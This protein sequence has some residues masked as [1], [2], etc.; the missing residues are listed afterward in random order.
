M[1]TDLK[2]QYFPHDYNASYDI[3]I[4]AIISEC[5]AIGYGIYWRIIEELHKEKGKIK[6]ND[7]VLRA[8]AKQMR[9]DVEQISKV[10]DTGIECDLF[11]KNGNNILCS[12]RVER[13]LQKRKEISKK[14][15]MA[16]KASGKS[17]KNKND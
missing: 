5:G 17:R 9:T 16:G 12:K 3:K 14:R 6:M 7:P 2:D 4:L 13:N 11:Y 15:S 8:L 1:P 10:I